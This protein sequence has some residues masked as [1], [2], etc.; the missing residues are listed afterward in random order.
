MLKLTDDQKVEFEI[1][2]LPLQ[3]RGVITDDQRTEIVRAILG[4]ELTAE[5]AEYERHAVTPTQEPKP[6]VRRATA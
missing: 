4:I 6:G 5:E 1:E 2:L 3:G